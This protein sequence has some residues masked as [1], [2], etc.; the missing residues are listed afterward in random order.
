MD[1]T[2]WIVFCYVWMILY[3]IMIAFYRK[4]LKKEEERKEISINIV[5]L[6]DL[7]TQLI[8]LKELLD[9][10]GNNCLSRHDVDMQEAIIR[11]QDNI[12]QQIEYLSKKN[13]LSTK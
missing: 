6:V 12:N 8:M 13:E 5:R 3:W 2:F 10:Q 1:S 11:H 9:I 7:R 4:E